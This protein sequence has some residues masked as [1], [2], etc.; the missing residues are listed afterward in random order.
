MNKGLNLYGFR[1]NQ[2]PKVASQY[3]VTGQF[4]TTSIAIDINNDC[5]KLLN[6]I[7]VIIIND[8]EGEGNLTTQTAG[9]SFAQRAIIDEFSLI[10]F[11]FQISTVQKKINWDRLV[12]SDQINSLNTNIIP[13]GNVPPSEFSKGYLDMNIGITG[14]GVTKLFDL[15]GSKNIYGT[16]VWGVSLSHIFEPNQ[17]FYSIESNLPRKIGIQASCFMSKTKSKSIREDSKFYIPNLIMEY[18]RGAEYKMPFKYLEIGLTRLKPPFYF[19]GAFRV[20]EKNADALIIQLG[21]IKLFP[22]SYKS[23]Y[24]IGFGYD[25]TISK[26]RTKNTN[27]TPEIYIKFGFPDYKLFCKSNKL[28]GSHIIC[29]NW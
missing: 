12:F 16:F 26:L 27:G 17:S 10:Q 1:R 3:K 14:I 7:G 6:G 11:G 15:N 13:T 18:Q 2:W 4:N 22:N 25:L 5:W 19:G 20:T 28:S 21:Y 9:I 8:I 23:F 24:K 29:P